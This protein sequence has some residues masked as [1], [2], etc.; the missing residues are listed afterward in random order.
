MMCGRAKGLAW[1][2]PRICPVGAMKLDGLV[3]EQDL[4]APG[5]LAAPL[6]SLCREMAL[7]GNLILKKGVQGPEALS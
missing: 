3:A 2:W 4:G 1:G 6:S 5:Q 7:C